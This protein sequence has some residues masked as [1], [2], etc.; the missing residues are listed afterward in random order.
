MRR[1]RPHSNGTRQIEP[2]VARLAKKW[3]VDR[4]MDFS[5][6]EAIRNH[7]R[8]RGSRGVADKVIARRKCLMAK[9]HLRG[10]DQRKESTRCGETAYIQVNRFSSLICD[11]NS[12]A[13]ML[14][15]DAHRRIIQYGDISRPSFGSPLPTVV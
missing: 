12:Y 10:I 11:H 3:I 5:L 15:P 6:E 13:K 1:R 9:L 7:G 2:V 14:G 8:Y 4:K